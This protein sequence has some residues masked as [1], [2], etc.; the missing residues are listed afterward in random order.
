WATVQKGRNYLDEK[1]AT[2][3]SVAEAEAVMESVLGKAWQLAELREKGYSRQNLS[4]LELA[5]ERYDDKAGEMR[6]EVSHLLDLD[7]GDV[8]QG[9]TF[10]PFKAMQH[11]A[12]QPSYSQPLTVAEAAIYPGFI[13]RRVRWDKGAEQ[14]VEPKPDHLKAAYAKANPDFKSALDAFRKQ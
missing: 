6:G 10:R 12:E 14:A 8:L 9:I 1:L 5:F 11:I 2:D 7:S 4:L 13:N 3:E